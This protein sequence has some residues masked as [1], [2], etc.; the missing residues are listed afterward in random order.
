MI[1]SL[2]T[3]VRVPGEAPFDTAHITVYYPAKPTGS[4]AERLSGVIPVDTAGA[5]LPV[6]LFLPGVNVPSTSY[7]WLAERVV[8]GG[9]VFATFDLVGPLFGGV[10]GLTPGLDLTAVMPDGYGSKSPGTAIRPV[11]DEL[12]R[13]AADGVLAGSLDMDRVVLGGHSAGGTVALESASPEWYPEIVGVF[14]YGAH[15]MVAA[16]L[17][18]DEGTVLVSPAD[19]PVLLVVGEQDGI[20]AASKDRYGG[21]D[22]HDPV[23]RTFREALKDGHAHRLEVLAGA[24]H[25]A[26]VHPEDPT[27]ARGF[28]DAPGADDPAARSTFGDLVNDF[29]RSTAPTPEETPA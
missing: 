28:L 10:V 12:H 3:A 9:A 17:G 18:W 16:A 15:T 19:C 25:M 8:A 24:S 4:D 11:I 5:P 1:R 2:R 20:M 21:G 23:T 29:I 26:V 13:L 7:R 6:V 14:V 27:T 22:A